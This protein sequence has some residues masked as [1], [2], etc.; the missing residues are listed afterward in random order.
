MADCSDCCGFCCATADDDDDDAFDDEAAAA[1]AAA[2]A[3]CLCAIVGILSLYPTEEEGKALEAV[4]GVDARVEERGW[5]GWACQSRS[6]SD[7]A[8]GATGF[9]LP[10]RSGRKVKSLKIRLCTLLLNG[11]VGREAT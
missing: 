10:T 11:V 6:F 1:A 5:A 9:P 8:A 2:A 3:R 4:G 7:A